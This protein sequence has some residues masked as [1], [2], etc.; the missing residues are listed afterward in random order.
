MASVIYLY[1]NIKQNRKCCVLY[2][3]YLRV[4]LL[5]VSTIYVYRTSKYKMLYFGSEICYLRILKTIS[6]NS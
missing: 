2:Y 3:I 1:S 4:N 6:N 5:I